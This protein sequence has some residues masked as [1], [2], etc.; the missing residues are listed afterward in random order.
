MDCEAIREQLEAYALGTLDPAEMAEIE[1]HLEACADCRQLA[2]DWEEIAAAL[3]RALAV[4]SP[5]RPPPELRDR[6]LATLAETRLHRPDTAGNSMGQEA[7]A[8]PLPAPSPEG[9]HDAPVAASP[10]PLRL[11]PTAGPGLWSRVRLAGTAAAVI[12]LLLSLA[13]GWRL[14][15]A[16]ARQRELSAGFAQLASQIEGEQEI[17]LE[18]IDSPRTVKALLKPPPGTPPSAAPPYGK[19]YTRPDL[20]NVVAMVARL[21]DAPAG[22]HYHLWLT[23]DGHVAL[24]G[25]L[26]TNDAGFGLLVFDAGHNGPVYD[27][28]RLTL[29]PPGGTAPGGT[30]VLIW[31]K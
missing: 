6:L 23:S 4:A 16:L 15:S 25:I 27:A 13:W 28:A 20:P 29:Q 18:V 17:V 5:H 31:E 3:P 14:N 12:L 10:T 24:A 19:L 11:P 30:T 2:A 8:A 9:Q 21:P 22:Q 7:M 26:T 1:R